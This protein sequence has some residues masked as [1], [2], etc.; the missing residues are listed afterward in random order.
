MSWDLVW[1]AA[2]DTAKLLP[3]L[4]LTYL[5]LE[6]LEHKLGDRS[7]QWVE[8]A[9]KWGP[10]YGGLCGMIPQCGFS[11]AAANLYAGRII[12][13]GTL[14]AVFLSTSDEMLPV[15]LSQQAG[16]KRILGIVIL[17]AG[18]G[19]LWGFLLDWTRRKPAE[20]EQAISQFCRKEGCQCEKSVWLGALAHTGSVLAFLFLITLGLN[21]A[22]ALVGPETLAGG[23]LSAPVAGK[24]LAG[25]VGMIPNCGASVIL[26]QLY[27]QGVISFGAMMAGLLPGAGVGLLVLFRVNGSKKESLAVAAKL[28]GAGIVS[29][30]ILDGMGVRL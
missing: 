14:A 19:I 25:L 1:D 6:L 20:P 13:L 24:L 17:K 21:W 29:G 22:L 30:L 8:K 9:G 26:T 18:L 11:A 10:V 16:M 5:A 7:R 23:I 12:T 4:F 15:M 28:Y 2:L 3:F 27:L